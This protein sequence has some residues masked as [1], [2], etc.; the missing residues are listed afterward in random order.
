MNF[1]HCVL[2]NV[3]HF[4]YRNVVA[5]VEKV[6]RWSWIAATHVG[7]ESPTEKAFWTHPQNMACEAQSAHYDSSYQVK[8]RVGSSLCEVISCDVG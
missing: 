2:C 7:N 8:E 1:D 3:S 5:H 4:L 6:T